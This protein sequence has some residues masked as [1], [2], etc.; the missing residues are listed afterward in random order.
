MPTHIGC[1][2]RHTIFADR[3]QCGQC[4]ACASGRSSSDRCDPSFQNPRRTKGEMATAISRCA[5]PART[6]PARHSRSCADSTECA[7]ARLPALE[8]QQT[9]QRIERAHRLAVVTRQRGDVRESHAPAAFD[10]ALVAEAVVGMRVSVAR[11]A[12]GRSR[13]DA[14][15]DSPGTRWNRSRRPPSRGTTRLRHRRTRRDIASACL[16]SGPTRRWCRAARGARR[17]R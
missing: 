7:P 16:P 3:F 5:P 9:A 1:N 13:R 8:R 12:R 2:G 15:P 4:G 17:S 14:A 11:R 6:S 10:V